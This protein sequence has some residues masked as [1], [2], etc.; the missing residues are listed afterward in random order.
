MSAN[1]QHLRLIVV[2]HKPNATSDGVAKVASSLA[3]SRVALLTA[4]RGGT[5][6]V[7]EHHRP[8]ITGG[9]E[10][11]TDGWIRRRDASIAREMPKTQA[12]SGF[13]V[14]TGISDLTDAARKREA[15]ARRIHPSGAA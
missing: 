4:S 10:T 9:I 15:A 1:R 3:R 6:G 7:P 11:A 5:D 14:R 8:R 2:E 13:V 12:S